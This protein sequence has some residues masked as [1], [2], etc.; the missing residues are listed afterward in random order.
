MR[1]FCFSPEWAEKTD[2]RIIDYTPQPSKSKEN[3]G[4]FGV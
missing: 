1:D 4:V 3:I 2:L